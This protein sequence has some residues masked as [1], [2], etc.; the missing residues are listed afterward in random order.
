MT[1]D[2]LEISEPDL[3]KLVRCIRAYSEAHRL[4]RTSLK[5]RRSLTPD[6]LEAYVDLL[7]VSFEF[8]QLLQHQSDQLD[9][10]RP[11]S[12]DLVLPAAES[13]MLH[14]CA[15]EVQLCGGSFVRQLEQYAQRIPPYTDV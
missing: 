8:A 13:A 1:I 7:T 9:D 6:E 3:D 12:L 15:L 4:L 2:P 14:V 11:V 5:S 10:G